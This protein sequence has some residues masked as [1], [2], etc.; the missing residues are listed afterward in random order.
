MT[1]RTLA[2]FTGLTP[3]LCLFAP[4]QAATLPEVTFNKQIAPIIYNNC[5]SCH[6]P[7]EAAPFSLL[8]YQD[9]AKRGKLIAKVTQSRYMPPW[10]AEK[11]SFEF[12]DERILKDSDIALID[13]WVKA[14]MPEGNPADAPAAPKFA[15]GWQLGEPD[16]V[17]EVPVAY[18]V[19]ADGPDI[20]RNIAVP[21]N[22]TEDKWLTAIDMK[23]TARSV[24]HHVLYF[25]DPSGKSHLKQ[26]GDQIGFSGIIPGFNAVGLG[27][28]ALGAQPHLLPE[29]LA[30]KVKAGTD[31]IVQYHFHPDGKVETE[32]ATIGL[33]F[34]R[35]AP[36]RTISGIQLPPSFGVFSGLNI[37]PGE[38]DYVVKDSFTLPVD[39]DA[40]SVG[41]HAH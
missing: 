22:L 37:P 6:R 14:G 3:F 1:K 40:I 41:A 16:M 13:A 36:T 8:S 39:Y 34:A 31:F 17:I 24:V 27:G 38:K 11:T 15:S 2:V 25:G 9:V 21:L 19:P 26:E 7:G 23:P 28:W 12:K 20:Y 4:L 5:S 18:K 32:K 29:G 33:Y 35:Q 10:K 30:L